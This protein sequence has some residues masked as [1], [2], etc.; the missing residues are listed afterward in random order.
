[1]KKI[2][3][4]ALHLAYGGVEK[5]ICGIANA[6][7]NDYSVEVISMYQ[8]PDAPAYPLHPKVKVRYLLKDIPNKKELREAVQKHNPFLMCKE[9]CKAAK[10]LYLKKHCLKKVIREIHSGII[11][12]TRKEDHVLLS[13]YGNSNVRKIAQLHHD[14]GFDKKL[15]YDI[16]HHYQN[17]DVFVLLCDQLKEETEQMMKGYND[18]TKCVAIPNFLEEIPENV[19]YDTRKP[20]CIAVGRL[21]AV[22]G[23]DRMITMFH[24]FHQLHPQWSLQIIGSGE[25]YDR[26]K[27]MIKQLHANEYIQLPGAKNSTEI[28]ALMRQASVY[29]M[30]SYSEGFPFVLLEAMSC[31]LAMVAYD[32]RVGPRAII[33][34]KKS[35]YLIKDGNENDF[36]KALSLLSQD[37]DLRKKMSVQAY[38]DV[39][40]YAKETVMQ[41][42]YKILETEE[43]ACTNN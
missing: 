35:G 9:G 30:T 42:W 15:I 40:S 8:M 2:Y 5:A 3:I 31:G 33:K 1:M 25:E 28:Q 17:I 43:D 34:D 19:G 11:I 20:V 32:V 22:K 37:S 27:E 29:V 23:F 26:L 21:H 39:H 13:R 36:I 12:S 24:K 4:L 10:I 7:V 41:Q 18:K 38:Q 6:L 16:Q 14:H